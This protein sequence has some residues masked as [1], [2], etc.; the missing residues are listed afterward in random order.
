MHARLI[1][2]ALA[3][4]SSAFAGTTTSISTTLTMS[5]LTPN[6]TEST[7]STAEHTAACTVCPKDYDRNW[8]ADRVINDTRK[9]H[10][11]FKLFAYW[12]DTPE[13]RFPLH[14]LSHKE[15]RKDMWQFKF[16]SPFNNSENDNATVFQPKWNLH[17]KS[18]ETDGSAPIKETLYFR[19]YNG[20]YPKDTE[21]WIGAVYHTIAVANKN[22]NK[23]KKENDSKLVAK[24]GWSLERENDDPLA[25][26]LKGSEPAGNFYACFDQDTAVNDALPLITGGDNDEQPDISTLLHASSFLANLE[27]VYSANVPKHE[28]ATPGNSLVQSKGCTRVIVKVCSC[29]AATMLEVPKMTDRY[30]T[31]RR[32]DQPQVGSRPVGALEL[33]TCLLSWLNNI[34]FLSHFL[35]LPMMI[36][37][38]STSQAHYLR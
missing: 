4:A 32:M 24:K 16:G 29:C 10:S 6:H 38:C 34:A 7:S 19:L 8:N 37:G 31:G 18:L 35:D 12:K 27:L 5:N 23:Y 36:L 26:V 17:D 11:S 14:V 15:S 28:F 21:N 3:L 20:N 22:K 1:A 30:L 33:V 9:H 25:Y 2:T 13:V